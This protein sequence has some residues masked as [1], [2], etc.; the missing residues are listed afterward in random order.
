MFRYFRCLETGR[1][2]GN[3]ERGGPAVRFRQP[4]AQRVTD[5]RAQKTAGYGE[6]HQPGRLVRRGPSGPHGEQARVHDPLIK[7]GHGTFISS[8][9]RTVCGSRAYTDLE[10]SFG[11]SECGDQVHR[12]SGGHGCQYG[13][14]RR[15]Q[16]SVT[17]QFD[18]SDLI[19]NYTAD[20]LRA[21]IPIKERTQ[22][23][24]A[25]FWTPLDFDFLIEQN[26]RRN[27]IHF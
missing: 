14:G 2:T 1:R 11:G 20:Q 6:R 16:E 21:D 12:T 27:N 18:A 10:H 4:S 8:N 19:A 25:E 24:T 5:Y 9:S 3:V 17:D 23:E 7:P 13:Q 26:Q 15:G 22:Y